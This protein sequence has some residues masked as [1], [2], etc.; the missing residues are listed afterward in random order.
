MVTI[1]SLQARVIGS[2]G[3]TTVV[4]NFNIAGSVTTE[5]DL[6]QTLRTEI[7]KIGGRNGRMNVI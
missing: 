4:N 5:R 2:G 1:A 7:M 6:A 3:G